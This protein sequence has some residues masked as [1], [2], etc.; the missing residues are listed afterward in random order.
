ML[1]NEPSAQCRTVWGSVIGRITRT[2]SAPPSWA[3]SGRR[4]CGGTRPR[5]A[6]RQTGLHGLATAGLGRP[7]AGVVNMKLSVV[8]TIPIAITLPT[9]DGDQR[10]D[11][12]FDDTQHGLDGRHREG[13]LDPAHQRAARHERQRRFGVISG[14]LQ[15][16][17]PCNG[18]RECAPRRDLSPT[19][20]SRDAT[21]ERYRRDMTSPKDIG[22]FRRWVN[23]FR[24]GSA[25]DGARR[26]TTASTGRPLGCSGNAQPCNGCQPPR[27][28]PTSDHRVAP[29]AAKVS[30]RRGLG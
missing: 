15:G 30:V 5:M 29:V 25:S 2:P 13:V 18:E 3:P 11:C 23:R 22:F 21:R 28:S 20:A 16:T 7:H 12:Q 4:R 14:E 6:P 17:D 10:G 19:G 26:Y 9:M 1:G 8:T 27:H 24:N